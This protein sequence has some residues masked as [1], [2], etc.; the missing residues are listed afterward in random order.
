MFKIA[1]TSCCYTRYGT[2]HHDKKYWA[3]RE[4]TWKIWSWVLTCQN[5]YTMVAIRHNSIKYK[6]QLVKYRT[7][8]N[9]E[10]KF[11]ISPV[12]LSFVVR[13]TLDKPASQNVYFRSCEL[14]FLIIVLLRAL[15]QQELSYGKNFRKFEQRGVRLRK[16]DKIWWNKPKSPH[17]KWTKSALQVY[18][19]IFRPQVTNQNLPHTLR[20]K[21]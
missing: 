4:E 11:C 6:A 12:E 17:Q 5:N 1:D 7:L 20:F 21:L 13:T 18:F 3:K 10:T 8:L 14:Y 15:L 2:D 16:L 19:R 9:R